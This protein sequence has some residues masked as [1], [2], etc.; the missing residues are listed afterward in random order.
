MTTS[1]ATALRDRLR[2]IIDAEF[3]AEGIVT[4]SDKLHESLG[5]DGAV[6]AVYPDF[7]QPNDA[8]MVAQEAHI[9]VQFFNAYDLKI[10]PTQEVDPGVIENYAERFKR[11][12]KAGGSYVGD[13]HD[14][15]FNVV[16]IDYPDDPTGNK[17]R[18]VA[19]VTGFAN[20]PAETVVSG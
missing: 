13:Q 3:T 15:Y 7:E 2:S 4:R 5:S 6:A 8:V 20:N 16:R 12:C 18:F 19:E 1:P 17:S 14:W 9:I 10:D 11:A